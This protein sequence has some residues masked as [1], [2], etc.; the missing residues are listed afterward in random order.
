MIDTTGYSTLRFETLDDDTILRVTIDRADSALNA[1]NEALHHDLTRV[2]AALR[3]EHNLRAIVLTGSDGAF[4]AGGD[5]EWFPKLRT[6]Q[7]L[8]ALRVDAKSMIWDLLDIE[9]PIVAA[10][11]GPAIGLGATIALLCD[12]IV[13]A[14]G[15]RIADPH[16]KV[17][18]VAGDGGAIIW[19]LVLGPALAKEYLLTGKPLLAEDAARLGLVNHVVPAEV[20]QEIA[21]QLARAIA[22][23]PPLAVRY[24][25]AVVNKGIRER[26]ETLFDYAAA[27]ELS[28]FLSE[29]HA[30]ALN[31][32][33][34]QRPPTYRG[35]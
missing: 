16:V 10:I 3:G 15:V 30:E 23:N 17:G 1:V 35:R 12:V 8:A 27:L 19:P 24:T 33:A 2:F 18:L 29:D 26:M 21:L 11:G 28:T 6:P 25:K 9:V 13:V 20:L 4:S 31:A 32:I 14:A 7:R 5:Y 22:A 34:E